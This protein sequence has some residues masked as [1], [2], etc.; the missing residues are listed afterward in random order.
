M[1]HRLGRPGFSRNPPSVGPMVT[2]MACTYNNEVMMEDVASVLPRIHLTPWRYVRCINVGNAWGG[3]GP[4]GAN[5]AARA[6]QTEQPT[7]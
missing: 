7:R 2:R 1:L 5:A 6:G 3:M 4:D